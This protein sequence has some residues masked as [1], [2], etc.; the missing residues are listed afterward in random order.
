MKRGAVPVPT[1]ILLTADEVCSSPAMPA[2]SRGDDAR[3]LERAAR[4]SSNIST[5]CAMCS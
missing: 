2:P 1:S 3:E 5:A 4:P